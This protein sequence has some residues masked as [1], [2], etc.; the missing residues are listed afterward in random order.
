MSG[1]WDFNGPWID[2]TP[3]LGKGV[4]YTAQDLPV[5]SVL[6]VTYLGTRY[7]VHIVPAAPENPRGWHRYV[8]RDRR[9]KTLS[10]IAAEITGDPTMSGN[11]FFKLRRRR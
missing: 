3:M 2:V 4:D 8:Y 9:Y 11:R 7:T 10:S 6:A 5:G 1:R